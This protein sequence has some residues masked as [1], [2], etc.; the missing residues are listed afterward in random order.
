MFVSEREHGSLIGLT[1]CTL[2][3]AWEARQE[4]WIHAKTCGVCGLASGGLEG[5]EE[6]WLS[7]GWKT[8]EVLCF[9]YRLQARNYRQGRKCENISVK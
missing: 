7:A 8:G 2:D 9:R 3:V 6:S 1:A 5:G 4:L